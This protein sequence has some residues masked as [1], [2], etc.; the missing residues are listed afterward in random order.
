[1]TEI[2][3]DI[4]AFADELADAIRDRHREVFPEKPEVVIKPD[5]T[6]VTPLDLETEDRL[7]DMIEARYPDHGI[8]GEE[9]PTT[10]PEAEWMWIIDPIDGTKSFLAGIPLYTLLIGLVHD[11][12]LVFGLVDQPVLGTR[13][14]G[15]AEVP[16]RC[17]GEPV[18]ARADARLADAFLAIGSLVHFGE[19]SDRVDAVVDA[20]RWTIVSR[21]SYL[22]GLIASGRLDGF[23]IDAMNLYDYA[24]VIPVIEGAGGVVVGADGKP[25]GLEP[26]E[27]M[28]FAANST[29]ADEIASILS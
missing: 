27:I 1:M 9:R 14:I 21:D 28:I 10:N 29:L 17:N 25:A 22:F 18:V 2:R 15:G 6:P 8:L 16:T 4:I 24:G 12:R 13:W 7:R 23:V 5:G 20:A 26:P 3:P 19:A 11:G